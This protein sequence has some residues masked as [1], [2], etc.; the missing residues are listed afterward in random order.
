MLP[1]I[2][3]SHD[4]ASLAGLHA[5]QHADP[6]IV[7][8]FVSCSDIECLK[9]DCAVFMLMQEYTRK[10]GACL[11]E[12]QDSNSIQAEQRLHR[13]VIE[14]SSIFTA[15]SLGNPSGLKDIHTYRM[16]EDGAQR[17]LQPDDEH[18][19]SVIVRTSNAV[20]RSC[21][22][23]SLLHRMLQPSQ[24]RRPLVNLCTAAVSKLCCLSGKEALTLRPCASAT[25]CKPSGFAQCCKGLCSILSG[26]CLQTSGCNAGRSGI[27]RRANTGFAACQASVLCSLGATGSR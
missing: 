16:N 17:P 23:L 1:F 6:I 7:S 10:L 13:W 21:F 9:K 14:I 12:I 15:V 20:R 2:H 26:S 11:M 22:S 4:L 19:H 18:Y 25:P 8:S 5:C 27:L 3:S 24:H